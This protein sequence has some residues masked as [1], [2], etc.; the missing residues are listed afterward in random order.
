MI[1]LILGLMPLIVIACVVLGLS[2]YIVQQQDAVIIER[3]GKFNRITGAGIHLRIPVIE[4]I[5]E[6]VDLRTC[7]ARYVLNGKTKDNVTI[8]VNVSVQ[9]CVNQAP[10]QTY[11]EMGIYRS[12]YMLYNPVEQMESFIADALRSAIPAYDLDQV[13]DNKDLIAQNVKESIATLMV[14][15]GFDVVSALITNIELPQDVER[16]MNAINSA[17]R[18]Q[19]AATALAEAERI[20]TVVA[21]KADA[22]AMEQTG[23]GIAAQRKAIAEGISESLEVIKQSGV[24]T[25]EANNL[26]LY[27]QWTEMMAEFAKSGTSHTVM[28]PSSFDGKAPMLESLLT[29][30]ENGR[31][32]A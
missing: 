7:E 19:E 12:H 32:S 8:G 27:T 24:S 30:Q 4:T 3:F 2:V 16:S 9:Y 10:A 23:I 15:Y 25:A 28:L 5:A 14:G 20:K 11:E 22:E 21:A 13:F 6:R 31:H 1:G 17:Q 18:N 26:F 29:A